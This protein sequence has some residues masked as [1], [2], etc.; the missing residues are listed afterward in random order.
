MTT[1]GERT[2]RHLLVLF[3]TQLAKP[4]TTELVV[5]SC[6]EF[7]IERNNEWIWFPASLLDFNWCDAI[8]ILA[9][10]LMSKHFDPM[11][12]IAMTTLPD[13]QRC[14]LVR[15]PV[16]ASGKISI[17]IRVPSQTKRTVHD[18][19][20]VDLMHAAETHRHRKPST[21]DETLLCLYHAKAWPE[22]FDLAVKSHKT[23]AATGSTGSGKSTLLK[24]LT[25]AIP[26]NE[27]VVTIEDTDE[28]GELP[29]RNRVSLFFGSAGITAEIL[30]ETSL[31]MRP[32]RV[33]MQELR[34][35]EAFAYIRLLAAGHPG[36]LTTW[37]AEDGDPFTPLALM[38]KQHDAGRNIPDDKLDI[39]LRSFI[40]IV[41]FCRR[42]GNRFSVPSVWFRLAEQD[43]SC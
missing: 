3:E 9:A 20:F 40:D 18:A 28:F 2:L 13:G 23:I 10:G 39:I 16:T 35:P 21:T 12:P 33:L 24:R 22:F 17:T 42:D 26:E 5:N 1:H 32:D 6:G 37:H 27:R 31:R 36:G 29:T 15:P 4:G 30:V 41:A 38:A 34:G 14:T 7:G 11:H 19:D 25:Q 43:R 8:G